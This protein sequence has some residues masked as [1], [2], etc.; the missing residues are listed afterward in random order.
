MRRRWL[1]VH[2]LVTI[3]LILVLITRF[4]QYPLFLVLISALWFVEFIVYWP[5]RLVESIQHFLREQGYLDV[6]A[7]YRRG[8]I[9][10]R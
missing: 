8:A 6:H 9:L 7:D 2:L 3:A 10:V 4:W 1:A 5:C